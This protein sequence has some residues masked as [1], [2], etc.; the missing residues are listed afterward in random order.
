MIRKYGLRTYEE[1][2]KEAKAL[3]WESRDKSLPEQTTTEHTR[4]DIEGKPIP[5]SYIEDKATGATAYLYSFDERKYSLTFLSADEAK[6]ENRTLPYRNFPKATIAFLMA[7][8]TPIFKPTKEVK[9]E[10]A[11]TPEGVNTIFAFFGETESKGGLPFAHLA[12]IKDFDLDTAFEYW[13]DKEGKVEVGSLLI[14][15]YPQELTE[16]TGIAIKQP[17]D[18]AKALSKAMG[19]KMSREQTKQ[20]KESFLFYASELLLRY[21]IYEFFRTEDYSHLKAVLSSFAK[22]A[23]PEKWEDDF[24][25]YY[26]YRNIVAKQYFSTEEYVLA[27]Y[28]SKHNSE[29]VG[30]TIHLKEIADYTG[31]PLDV[32]GRAS[33]IKDIW[34]F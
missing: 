7:L 5:F 27:K 1:A 14:L 17:S 15:P 32:M 33:R 31:T 25:M 13:E 24:T 20:A 18:F 4:K 12:D 23:L 16:R 6:P 2:L 34:D 3:L 21:A 30:S 22:F 11:L 28:L 29:I 9:P 19:V 10:E 26:G 8:R